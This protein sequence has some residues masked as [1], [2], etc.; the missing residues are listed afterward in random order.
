MMCAP[1]VPGSISHG[2]PGAGFT[3]MPVE[4]AVEEEPD[5]EP[6]REPVEA[7]AVAEEVPAADVVVGDE[8][9]V[10]IEMDFEGATAAHFGMP[11]DHRH[12]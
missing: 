6:E 5:P 12:E 8:P 4:A 7:V 1:A 2:T 9:A 11:P 3:G 10:L